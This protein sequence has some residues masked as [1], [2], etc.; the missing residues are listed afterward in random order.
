MAF[1]NDF[2][3]QFGII[4]TNLTTNGSSV[5]VDF[6]ISFPIHWRGCIGITNL[7]GITRSGIIIDSG[8]LSS[9]KLLFY[10]ESTASFK[11]AYYIA[12]GY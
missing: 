6:P 9:M 8:S 2:I 11:S 12:V 7:A 3:V 10:C 5:T 1:S 4:T